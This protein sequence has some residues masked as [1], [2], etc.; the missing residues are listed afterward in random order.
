MDGH[1]DHGKRLDL[2]GEEGSA[3]RNK[4]LIRKVADMVRAYGRPGALLVTVNSVA[5]YVTAFRWALR[6]KV[7][8]KGPR[9]RRVIP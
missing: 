5:A 2:G 7:P 3:H 6:P 9:R 8:G 1:G 4:A